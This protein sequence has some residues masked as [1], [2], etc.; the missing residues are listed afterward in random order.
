MNDDAYTPPSYDTKRLYEEMGERLRR[1][2]ASR[3]PAE[4][5]DDAVQ[6]I[7]LRLHSALPRLE[8][9]ECAGPWAFGVARRALADYWRAHYATV[10]TGAPAEEGDLPDDATP[11]ENLATYAGDHDV[12][13]EVLSWLRPLAESLP[14]H[15]RE[16]LLLADFEGLTQREVASR[17][18]LSLS[19]AKSRVQ[20]AR[21]RL[22]ELLAACC[23]VEFGP[24]ARAVAFTR[25]A[26]EGD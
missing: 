7:F 11:P 3:V 10:R 18:G 2:A 1:F 12:H 20:R 5:V 16:P 26:P 8:C 9:D 4:A 22:A 23:A 21:A 6:E 13:Q 19:G 15:D 24:E 17:L 25:L 14:A